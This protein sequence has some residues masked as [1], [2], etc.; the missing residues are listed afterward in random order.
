MPFAEG[1][2]AHG[3]SRVPATV[4]ELKCENNNRLFPNIYCETFSSSL[5]TGLG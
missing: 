3:L 1:H 4:T 5:V 2:F